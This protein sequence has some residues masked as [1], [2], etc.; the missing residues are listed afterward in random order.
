MQLDLDDD[1]VRALL[2]IGHWAEISSSAPSGLGSSRARLSSC[3]LKS[4]ATSIRACN[5]PKA[6]WSSVAD[7]NR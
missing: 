6:T 7:G 1:E 5:C 3:A 4:Y 2:R